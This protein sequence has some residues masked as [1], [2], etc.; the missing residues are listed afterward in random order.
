MPIPTENLPSDEV[1]AL[2]AQ[3][4]VDAKPTA[5]EVLGARDT[6]PIDLYV[7]DQ[8]IDRMVYQDS[9]WL[10]WRLWGAFWSFVAG[11]LAVPE[12]QSAITAA[13]GAALP[14]AYAPIV[15]AVLGVAWPL[16]SKYRD[17]RPVRDL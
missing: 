16:V 9:P 2:A 7:A 4:L 10:S 17:L 6:S 11:V 5:Q 15:P 3:A 12:V 13:V 8:Q 14:V 1:Q